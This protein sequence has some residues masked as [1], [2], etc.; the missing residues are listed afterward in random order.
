MKDFAEG[1]M[2]GQTFKRKLLDQRM[3]DL[4]ED[5]KNIPLRELQI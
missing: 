5:N 3:D 4:E 1:N 2:D